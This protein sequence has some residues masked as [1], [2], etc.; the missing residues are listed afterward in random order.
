MS[1]K[2]GQSWQEQI[3]SMPFHN[4]KNEDYIDRQA[5]LSAPAAD[6]DVANQISADDLELLLKLKPE[7]GKVSFYLDFDQRCFVIFPVLRVGSQTFT[8]KD[9]PYYIIEKT[10]DLVEPSGRFINMLRYKLQRRQ[11]QRSLLIPEIMVLPVKYVH[12]VIDFLT[13]ILPMLARI[14]TV[15]YTD[16][17]K[18]H[19][20]RKK[21]PLRISCQ[22]KGLQALLRVSFAVDDS[23]TLDDI[24]EMLELYHRRD[25]FRFYQMQKGGIIDLQSDRVQDALQLLSRFGVTRSDLVKHIKDFDRCETP[26]ALSLLS[27]AGAR[28]AVT[29]DE[30]EIDRIRQ[31]IFTK[32]PLNQTMPASL[33]QILRPY[34][35][36]GFRWLST[37][38][39]AQLGGILADDMG[40]GK[41]LQTIALIQAM[42]GQYPDARTLIVVPTSLV[43]NW[44]SE[45]SRFA[46]T[47][48]AVALVGAVHQ[49]RDNLGK[50]QVHIYITTYGLLMN[51]IDQYPEDGFDLL[52]LDEAQRIKN[53]ASKSFK[54]VCKV[55]AG[56]RFALTGTPIENNLAELWSLFHALMPPL[57]KGFKQFKSI[58]MAPGAD[59][60]PLRKKISPFILRRIKRD[61]LKDLPEKTETILRVEMSDRQKQLYLA[62]R[63]QTL[64]MLE[65][66][67][68]SLMNVLA[69]L[70]RLRQ[71]CCHP[72]LFL[73]NFNEPVGKMEALLDI[74]SDLQA[75]N[76]RALVFSQFTSLLDLIGRELDQASI[77]YVR[78]D[79]STPQKERDRIVAGFASGQQTVFLISLRAG[80]VGLNLTAADTVIHCDPWWNPSVEE[81]ASARVYRIGQTRGVQIIHLIAHGSIEDAINEIKQ[82][83]REL[84][85]QLIQPT[86]A[87]IS[88]LSVEEI[89]ALFSWESAAQDARVSAGR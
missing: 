28:S 72:G 66:G 17:L 46:P 71:I 86:E 88:R 41:T 53:A 7:G 67:R 75:E 52:I 47:L 14:G 5:A 20:V 40:L 80:G 68:Q 70:T 3:Q 11:L 55:K 54:A 43:T 4:L 39:S 48:R 8:I 1:A 56:C 69:Q 9:D 84:I 35:V 23:L 22:T 85:D 44:L 81:Q 61:V 87:G 30:G 31:H 60:E 79:G 76:R 21:L 38:F 10:T 51:D 59:L 89:Q 74:V 12:E 6:A 42:L 18:K 50:A 77:D 63:E 2:Q 34:Q 15:F 29:V 78:L 16:N 13:D 73:E 24:M 19:L 37:L 65:D 64:Q 27:E 57:L 32:R 82:Q 62:Y 49:R 26:F 58:Y 33:S 25:G 45:I 83:K 36:E